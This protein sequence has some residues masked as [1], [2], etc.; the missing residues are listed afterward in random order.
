M[1]ATGD[2]VDFLVRVVGR[3]TAMMAKMK[4]GE[5]I[6]ATGPLGKPLP[7]LEDPVLVAGGIG[8]VPLAFYAARHG[9]RLLWGLKEPAPGL[10]A[11][12]GSLVHETTYETRS[13]TVVDLV[14]GKY[15]HERSYIACGPVPMFRALLDLVPRERVI[16]LAEGMMACG[17]GIC[18]G[19]A[20]PRAGGGF[21]RTCT[22]GP[23]FRAHD[24]DL[25]RFLG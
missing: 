23:W 19:C 21:L 11:V 16:L 3:A 5:D 15:A 25:G 6:L 24:V 1:R 4:E 10:E 12:P 14:A 18:L 17:V 9:G 22:E 8:V 13:G 20:L 2:R 7:E